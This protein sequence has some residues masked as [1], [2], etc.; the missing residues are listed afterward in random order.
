VSI[1]GLYCQNQAMRRL[2]ASQVA[3]VGNAAPILTITWG[4]TFLGESLGAS[5]LVGAAL[6][7]AGIVWASRPAR[8][9]RAIPVPLAPGLNAS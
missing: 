2:D 8:P 3:T 9:L 6:T 1:F 7:L 5:L 4:V